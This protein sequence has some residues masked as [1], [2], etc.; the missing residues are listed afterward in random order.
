M[1]QGRADEAFHVLERHRARGFLSLLSERS[2]VLTG[3]LPPELDAERR[4]ANTEYD[5]ALAGLGRSAAKDREASLDALQKARAKQEDVQRRLRTAAPRLDA[6]Q[7]L[8]PFD[9]ARTRAALDPGTLVL[10]YWVGEDKSYVF[11][12]GPG[13]HDFSAVPL[14]WDPPKLRAEVERFRRLLQRSEGDVDDVRQAGDEIGA[15]LLAPVSAKIAA[16]RRLLVVPDGP[17]HLLPF[18]ALRDPVPSA[19]RGYLAER[20]PIHVAASATV[21]AELR[22][23]RRPGRSGRLL[24][25]GDA[26]YSAVPALSRTAGP[27]RSA[28]AA[29][30]E[31]GALPATRA[32]VE[33]LRGLYPG[34]TI[35]TGAEVTEARVKSAGRDLSLLHFACHA[36]ADEKSPLDSSLVLSVPREWKEGE[37]NGLLQAWEI[38]EQMKLDADLVT[39]SACSTAA[40]QELSGEGILGLTR[41]FQYA[42][43][44]SVLASLWPVSDESTAELMKRFYGH[45]RRGRSKDAALQA[46]QREMLRGRG[47]RHPFYWAAFQV[48]GDWQ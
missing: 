10:S 28:A 15:V 21:F 39:L 23:Q 17:L 19:R 34:S 45:L 30:V 8:E 42:G 31:L 27:L 26:D 22:K 37:D 3:E 46:A 41:A 32:E 35:L 4:K 14:R 2:V 7:S 33:S 25:M 29:G 6:L 24:A 48:S 44:R 12:V 18:A 5:R 13:A 43:A 11:A 9:L 38:F 40:G 16:A 47:T 20:L 36:W 1:E